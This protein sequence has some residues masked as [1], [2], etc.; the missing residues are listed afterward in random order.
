MVFRINKILKR[1][2]DGKS[3]EEF[4][5]KQ[6]CVLYTGEFLAQQFYIIAKVET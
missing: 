3:W 6:F 2:L 1:L 4:K 5:D